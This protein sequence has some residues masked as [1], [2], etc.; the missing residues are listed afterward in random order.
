MVITQG[1][2]NAIKAQYPN[3]K[4]S[5][6][7]VPEAPKTVT[8]IDL[9]KFNPDTGKIEQKT[10]GNFEIDTFKTL[11]EK[12]WV[13]DLDAAKNLSGA[14]EKESTVVKEL[15][16]SVLPNEDLRKRYAEGKTSGQETVLVEGLIGDYLKPAIYFDGEIQRIASL[17]GLPTIWDQAISERK[18]KKLSVPK[19]WNDSIKASSENQLNPELK[20]PSEVKTS[21][22]EK[23]SID[24]RELP[25]RVTFE[26]LVAEAKD[27]G[28]AVGAPG[29]L[30]SA[31]NAG[32]QG[33]FL[34][35]FNS[36]APNTE[37]AES[38]VSSLNMLTSN[39]LIIALPGKDVATDS[40]RKQIEKTLP[41]AKDL[42]SGK[43]QFKNKIKETIAALDIGLTSIEVKLEPGRSTQS[44]R[45]GLLG[46]KAGLS[47]IRK[48]YVRMYNELN[49]KPRTDEE[50]EKM[51]QFLLKQAKPRS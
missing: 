14:R 39:F 17:N 12:G 24:P 33:L 3:S 6:K 26:N 16:Y 49:K 5:L 27:I 34:N 38:I 13:S 40:L 29:K 20:D 18:S 4:V 22:P 25:D 32:I 37:Q 46:D 15:L 35:Y 43:E 50:I 9:F 42:T 19:H 48:G 41:I 44:V 51:D 28:A 31:F 47:E 1:E 30:R 21:D 36:P 7:K 11:T 23:I 8:A 2:L 10:I 45:A